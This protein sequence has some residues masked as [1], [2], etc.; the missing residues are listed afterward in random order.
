MPYAPFNSVCR[1]LGCKNAKS[2]LN[3][4]CLDHGG[5]QHAN[6]G[7]DNAYS[8]PAWRTIRRAQLSKQP[9][10]QSCLTRGHVAS[11]LHV[12]HVFPWRQIG[13]HAFINN[14][15]QS[16]CHECHSHKTAQE[17]KGN[18]EHYTQDGIKNLTKSDYSYSM[19]QF[20][21]G[22]TLET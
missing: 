4:F 15:F 1:E 14:I 10:C 18:Y 11:A 3:S 21:G 16:L 13:E 2:K 22:E 7:K 12:D 17:R 20:H 5:L 6:E 19:S 8:N 9:L